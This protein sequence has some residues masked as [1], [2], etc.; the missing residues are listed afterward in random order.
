MDTLFEAAIFEASESASTKYHRA[1]N[2]NFE[3]GHFPPWRIEVPTS[4]M[5][6]MGRFRS[7]MGRFPTSMGCFPDFVLR[8]RLPLESPLEN[9]LTAH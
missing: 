2:G 5:A 1:L 6:L 4:T 9:C 7:L 3:R 8:G